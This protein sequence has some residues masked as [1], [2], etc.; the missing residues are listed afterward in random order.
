[1]KRA[2]RYL[3][4]AAVVSSLAGG[5]V[6]CGDSGGGGGDS[7]EDRIESTIEG[8]QEAFIDNDG[9]KACEH[10][11][12]RAVTLVGVMAHQTP[13]T[14]VLE[15][16][17]IFQWLR[18]DP[19]N[20][21]EPQD[22]QPDLIEADIRGT[23][24]MAIVQAD[25]HAPVEVP[26]VKSRGEWKLDSVFGTEV[27]SLQDSSGMYRPALVT[28]D[29][30]SA[31]QPVAAA[32]VKA[33]DGGKPC[34]PVKVAKSRL[35]GGGCVL[36]A[37]GKMHMGVVSLFGTWRFGKPCRTRFHVHVDGRGRAWVDAFSAAGPSPC[38][39]VYGC[40]ETAGGGVPIPWRGRIES[41]SD[42]SARLVIK[43]ACLDT[44]LG[45]YRGKLE[46]GLVKTADGW[47]VE[48]EQSTLGKSGWQIFDE[49]PAAAPND[50]EMK[51]S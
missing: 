35:L 9:K 12:K 42:E 50:L 19:R 45:L 32:D 15:M 4:L 22:P 21:G 47:R 31:R 16:E 26:F 49:V 5:I 2:M 18:G 8:L 11:T 43:R 27:A 13:A 36:A 41:A 14:C 39:D 3:L 40:G 48:T 20:P 10:V 33:T 28:A 29:E 30:E 17:K 25:G 44:C 23:R 51:A 46:L 7:E 34:P 37:K 24:A 1:M 6:A 38:P